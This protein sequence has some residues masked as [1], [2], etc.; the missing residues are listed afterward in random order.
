MKLTDIDLNDRD[1]LIAA[2]AL[3]ASILGSTVIPPVLHEPVAS[4]TQRVGDLSL[5][6]TGTV[7]QIQALQQL[8]EP[9]A[10]QVF[11]GNGAP[12]TVGVDP[13]STALAVLPATLPGL[14]ASPMPAPFIAPAAAVPG[15]AAAALMSPAQLA[16]DG[17]SVDLD[18]DG[19]PWDERIHAGTKSKNADGRWKAKKGINDPAL[20]ARVKAELQQ[21]QALPSTPI[22]T[23]PLQSAAPPAAASQTSLPAGLPPLPAALPSG[24]PSTF[25]QLM[26]RL[27]AASTAGT[28]PPD[29][30]PRVLQALGISSIVQV[31][32]DTTGTHVANI[33]KLVQQH[34]P[35]A[36]A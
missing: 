36:A 30:L 23:A 13:Q 33:W 6:H 4:V 1:E 12:S 32:S 15:G 7:Q 29:A 9:S 34:W 14:P 21:R 24:V 2:H 18:A 26:P 17:G 25:E 35:A 10:A 28:L 8:P 3:L 19:L 16:T 20:V 31:Q 27:T 5:T 11:G 22:P